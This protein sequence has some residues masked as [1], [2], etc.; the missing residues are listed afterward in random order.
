MVLLLESIVEGLL[1]AGE[2]FAHLFHAPGEGVQGGDQF[3][4]HLGLAL[5][6]RVGRFALVV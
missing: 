2:L 1:V 4:E 6:G 5:Q 3:R